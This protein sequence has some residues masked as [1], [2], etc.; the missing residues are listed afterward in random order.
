[1][2]GNTV[3]NASPGSQPPQCLV[4]TAVLLAIDPSGGIYTSG[5]G[6]QISD[7]LLGALCVRYYQ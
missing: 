5:V 2:S 7:Q 1:M 3:A 6:K 4:A